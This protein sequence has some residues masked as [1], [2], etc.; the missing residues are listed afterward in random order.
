V[1]AQRYLLRGLLRGLTQV[2]A[3][4]AAEAEAAA[5]QEIPVKQL[6][7]AVVVVEEEAIVEAL[8]VLVALMA[9]VL[10]WLEVH[11]PTVVVAREIVPLMRQELEALAEFLG[12][13]VAVGARAFT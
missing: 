4:A 6:L 2:L 9:A 10:E 11:L 7:A 8:G 13:A 3:A 12:P 1:L 5:V